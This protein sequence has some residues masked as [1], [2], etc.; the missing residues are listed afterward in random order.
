MKIPNKLK[1]G[2]LTYSICKLEDSN[3]THYGKCSVSEQKI[4]LAKEFTSE[5]AKIQTFF[6]ELTHIVLD[7]G[8]YDDESK[9][10]K[11]VEHIANTFY[12]VL[13]DNNLLK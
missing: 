3:I 7:I 5:E 10:E 2:N 6:H 4:W 1:V 11:F 13:K 9:N 8:R 12:Q